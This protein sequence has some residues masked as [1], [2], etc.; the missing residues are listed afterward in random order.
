MENEKSV[1]FNQAMMT[2]CTTDAS[3]NV[4]SIPYN[5]Y[6]LSVKENVLIN[7]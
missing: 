2:Q 3:V 4:S 5:E 7:P 1:L 6:E